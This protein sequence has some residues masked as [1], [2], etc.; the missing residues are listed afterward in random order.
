M[1][2]ICTYICI[3]GNLCLPA[4]SASAHGQID[5]QI[6]LFVGQELSQMSQL[7]IDVIR[8]CLVK[9][10][11]YRLH[12]QRR[13]IELPLVGATAHRERGQGQDVLSRVKQSL[14]SIG[15][16]LPRPH[17]DIALYRPTQCSTCIWPII[18]AVTSYTRAQWD[19][20]RNNNLTLNRAAYPYKI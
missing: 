11:L 19:Q 1:C 5:D 10:P 20:L 4:N 16:C 6:E 17:K 2:I 3:K 15:K 13:R 8:G 9:C 14:E 12:L 18:T 7:A